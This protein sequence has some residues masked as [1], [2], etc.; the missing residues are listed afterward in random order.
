[1][2]RFPQYPLPFVTDVNVMENEHLRVNINTNGTIDVLYKELNWF[3]QGLNYLTDQGECGDA[4][5]HVAPVSDEIV[6][7]N[8]ASA[9][10][11]LTADTPLYASY[12]VS[13]TMSYCT[14]SIIHGTSQILS[15][16][17]LDFSLFSTVNSAVLPVPCSLMTNPCL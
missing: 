12:R 7:S 11:V 14:V 15:T 9:N 10:I 5:K 3:I 17:V 4:W 1:M 6:S 2:L 16:N 13:Y 8:S